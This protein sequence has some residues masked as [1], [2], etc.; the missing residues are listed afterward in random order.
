VNQNYTDYELW[1]IDYG[2]K[3]TKTAMPRYAISDIHGCYRTFRYMV[4]EVLHLQPSDQLFLLGDYIDRG[5][6]AKGVIDYIQELRAK[7]Y[8]VATLM[9]NHEAMLVEARE[10][11]TYLPFWLRNGGDKTLASF[12]IKEITRLPDNYWT[13]LNQLIYYQELPDYLLVHAGFD[14]SAGNPPT[15]FEAMLWIRQFTVD[16]SFLGDRKIVHGHTPTPLATIRQNVANPG[17]SVYN[18]D[19]GCVFKHIPG[20]GYLTALNLDTRQIYSLPSRDR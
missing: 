7:G 10:D 4:E 6:D 11:E 8:G 17:S 16:P 3:T 5:P 13:F 20:Y 18:I 9:G 15:N 12:G 14:F 1:T 2:L 19:G